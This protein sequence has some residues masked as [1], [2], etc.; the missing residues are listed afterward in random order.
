MSEFRHAI[1]GCGRVAANHV[2]GFKRVS[3]WAIAAACDLQDHVASFAREHGIPRAARNEDEILLDPSIHSVTISVD[4][5]QH[6][7]LVEKAL[8]SGKHV[9]VEKPLCLDPAEGH[10]LI[11]LAEERNLVLSV[12]A[13]HRYDPVVEAMDEW[14]TKGLLGSLVFVRATLQAHRPASYYASSYWR[15]SLAGEGGSALINQGYHC[16]DV[17][18]HL[19]GD[20]DTV[21][22]LGRT[23]GLGSVIETEDTL[24]A[25]LSASGVPVLLGITVASFTE[26]CTRIEVVGRDGSVTF[27]LDH[28]GRLHH[29]MGTAELIS[30]AE[31]ENA[32]TLAEEPPGISYYG[33]SHRRQIADFCRAVAEGTP[34]R[35]GPRDALATLET[36]S[37]LYAAAS[38]RGI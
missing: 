14:I 11:A 12:V 36:I 26:W 29:W 25:L 16:L 37:A 35:F 27:D 9:L 5:R 4:H 23:V 6:A 21:A 3:G 1:I 32:R 13:Q 10:R 7:R 22:A 24:A 15:G 17:V 19:C 34:M 38:H 33:I 2:D 31:R 20:L 18:R 28:P 30:A 8:G